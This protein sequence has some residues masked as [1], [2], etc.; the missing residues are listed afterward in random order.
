MIKKKNKLREKNPFIFDRPIKI[1]QNLI[2]FLS[3]QELTLE[4]VPEKDQRIFLRP[5]GAYLKERDPVDITDSMPNK[6]KEIAVKAMKSIPG[7][8]HCDVDMI[9]NEETGEGYVNEINSRPQIS[10]HLFPIEGEARDVPKEIIDFYFP[11]T[12]N[13][14]ETISTI[15][16]LILFMIVSD[17]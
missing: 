6:I 3:E 12:I 13:G 2:D 14:K 15:M 1:D 16:I 4:S 9:V 7:L 10:N 8:T 17:Q 11:E 5:Q